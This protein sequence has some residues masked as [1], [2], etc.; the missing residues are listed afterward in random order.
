M[1]FRFQ[2]GLADHDDVFAVN[3]DLKY[4]A[5]DASICVVDPGSSNSATYRGG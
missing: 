2:F 3:S 4:Q 5:P 1:L